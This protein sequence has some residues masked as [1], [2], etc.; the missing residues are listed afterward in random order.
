M[1]YRFK[2]LIIHIG[3]LCVCVLVFVSFVSGI[4]KKSGSKT[5]KGKE[6]NTPT[7]ITSDGPLDV[8]FNKN[9][10]IFHDNVV[11]KDK[12]G[13]VYSD[14]MRV[15]FKNEN[16]EISRVEAEGNVIIY[17]DNKIA[18]GDKALYK[19]PEGILELTGNPRIQE[20]KNVYAADKITIFQK[21]GKTEMKLEPKARLLLYRDDNSKNGL[22][23]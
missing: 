14:L 4:E 20:N 6:G 17:V 19:V 7:V 22:L 5:E 9:I 8:D 3:V 2:Q 10:A 1:I 18:K 23:F 13:Q 16:R 12:N 21:N 15:F 11:I